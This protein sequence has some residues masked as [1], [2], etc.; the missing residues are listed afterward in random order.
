LRHLGEQGF[1]FGDGGIV[2]GGAELEHR[3][4]VSFLRRRHNAFDYFLYDTIVVRA[5]DM[6]P[7]ANVQSSGSRPGRARSRR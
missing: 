4:V 2:I 7:T 3:V 6:S 1:E 5:Q